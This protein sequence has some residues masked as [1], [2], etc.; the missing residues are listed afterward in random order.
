MSEQDKPAVQEPEIDSVNQETKTKEAVAY[1][2]YK[3]AIGEI[4]KLKEKVNLYE[5]EKQEFTEK[6]LRENQEWKKLADTY[7]GKLDETQKIFREQEESIVNGMKYQEFTKHLGGKLRSDDYASFVPFDKIAFNP[8]TKTIDEDSVKIVAA[9]FVKKHSHLVEFQAGRMPNVNTLDSKG[10]GSKNT[11][12]MTPKEMEQYI[13][14][15]N[16]AG[17]I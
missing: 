14:E 5:S 7:K 13:L 17:K 15:L 11:K 1:D 12:E 9:E 10:V 16:K 8:E 4:K 2:T 6:Q 3:R